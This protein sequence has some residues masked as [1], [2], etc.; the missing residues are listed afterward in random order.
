MRPMSKHVFVC[1]PD[2]VDFSG[3]A[4]NVPAHG[5]ARQAGTKV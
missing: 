5:A 1:P 3:L 2:Q 4:T